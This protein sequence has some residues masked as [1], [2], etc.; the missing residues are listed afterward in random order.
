MAKELG[1]VLI[2]PYTIA[3][4]RTGGVIARYM[5]LTDL[6]FVG[7]RMFAPGKELVDR[8]AQLIRHI[9]AKN[10]AVNH[11]IADYIKAAYSPDPATGRARRVMMLLFEGENAI[12]KL[13][14][15]TGSPTIKSGSGETVRDTYGDFVLDEN[16]RVRYYEP[17]VLVSPT[18]RRAAAT[19]CLWAH[20]AQR[21]PVLAERATDVPAG[22]TVEK[23]L[24]LLKPDNFLVPSSRPGNIIDILS[25]SGLRI[26]GVKRFYMT[27][28]QAEEFY[29]PV[30]GALQEKFP[31]FGGP[32]AADALAREFGFA[33]P[34]PC[35]QTVCEQLGPIF[36][37]QQFESI[38]QFMTGYK[39]SEVSAS[40]KARRGRVG[41]LALVYE[42]HEAVQKIR[43]IVGVTDP[44]QAHPGSV[45][46]EYG[47]NIM[48]NAIHASDSAENAV[49]EMRIIGINE[50]TVRP[51]IEK[52]YGGL[53][54]RLGG[55]LREA[56][57]RTNQWLAPAP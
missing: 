25:A 27:V 12:R 37:R 19:L 20:Y 14:T 22:P 10:A 45:R 4:S 11:L 21:V 35:L 29:G 55:S 49:R 46:R 34:A 9:D 38:V 40:E 6:N 7:A 32:R 23:T 26:V 43:S 15:V 48:V 33:V 54:T 8:Y 24:V 28:A 41:C 56:F 52:Y 39:P 17:A 50:D 3:K 47:S 57:H 53:M 1:F 18:R 42:G 5:R 44:S 16:G 36:A 31:K 2:N 13:W 51:Y 30:L